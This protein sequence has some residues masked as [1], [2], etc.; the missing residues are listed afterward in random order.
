MVVATLITL[1][2]KD[3]LIFRCMAK[4]QPSVRQSLAL[5]ALASQPVIETTTATGWAVGDMIFP[6]KAL[7]SSGL[8]ETGPYLIT[9]ISGTTITMN[10]NVK[11]T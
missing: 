10:N 2:R 8:T 6:G 3:V 5:D 1:A 4:Y 11:T 9:G 7:V